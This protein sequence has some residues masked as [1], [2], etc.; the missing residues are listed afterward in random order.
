M[1]KTSAPEPTRLRD[2]ASGRTDLMKMDPSLIKIEKGHNPR[3]Y[4]LPE[5]RAHLNSLKLSIASQKPGGA[6]GEIVGV[7]QPLI[8]RF[9]GGQCVLVDGESRLTAV[10]ELI[11]EGVAIV[12]VPVIQVTANTPADRV[13]IAIG[14]NT[15]KPLSEWELGGGFK[16]L[17]SFGWTPEM[18]ASRFGVTAQK[19][20]KCIE[21]AD[22]PQDVKQLLS[23]R[24][25]TPALAITTIRRARAKKGSS[26]D[27]AAKELKSEVDKRKAAGKKGPAK[28]AKK[29]T[30]K[31]SESA[32]EELLRL[33]FQSF[34]ADY[35]AE[36]NQEGG[37]GSEYFTVKL[38]HAKKMEKLVYPD[39]K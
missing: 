30:G 36:K 27:D 29:A 16:R 5:N 6:E 31:R 35:Y 20:V 4:R 2:L 38:G 8:C 19:V 14:A 3:D 17:E 18:I 39:G 28:A 37:F 34:E 1:A 33:I 12:T 22:M 23:E 32:A 24:A 10:L 26:V 21:L 15:G 25:I 9:D 11:K 7:M 13:A